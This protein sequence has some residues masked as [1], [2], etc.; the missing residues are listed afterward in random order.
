MPK[1]LEPP[2]LVWLR[3]FFLLAV[4][5]WLVLAGVL[6]GFL[7]LVAVGATKPSPRLLAEDEPTGGRHGEK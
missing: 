7:V 6:G 3:D 4:V 5:A 1:S 2:E